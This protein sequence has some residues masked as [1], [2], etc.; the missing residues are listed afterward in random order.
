[1]TTEFTAIE[2]GWAN[3]FR[4]GEKGYAVEM[5]PG[6]GSYSKEVYEGSRITLRHYK[7]YITFGKNGGWDL[8]SNKA[9]YLATIFIGPEAQLNRDLVEMLLGAT[10]NNC[11]IFE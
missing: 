4:H 9:N 7:G 8:A 11:W 10:E 6:I 1:M 3:I 5:C 2:P